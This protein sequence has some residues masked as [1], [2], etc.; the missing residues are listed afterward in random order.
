M[1]HHEPTQ[2]PLSKRAVLYRMPEME[3]VSVRKGNETMDRFVSE[4]LARNLPV[5]M[6][7]HPDAP[8]A[9]D[10]VHDSP[11]TRETIRQVLAFLRFYL[12]SLA[13]AD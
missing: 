9:F 11:T 7:N 2:H 1:S 6:V 5:A 10:L 8:H 13:P 3:S 12:R 4:A